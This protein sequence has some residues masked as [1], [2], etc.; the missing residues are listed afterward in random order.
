MD[1]AGP[2]PCSDAIGEPAETL[3]RHVRVFRPAAD[4]RDCH[5]DFDDADRRRLHSRAAD[6]AISANRAAGNSGAN[7]LHRGGR[8]HDRAIGRGADRAADERGRQ[9]E[10]HVLD[11]RE[12][13][14]HSIDR[15]FRR[16]DRP[17]HRSGPDPAARGAS[18]IAIAGRREQLRR[19]GQEIDNGAADAGFAL[20][21]QRNLRQHFSRELRLHQSVRSTH[22]TAGNWKR[23][24]FR[25]RPIRDALVGEAGS[26]R[27][28]WHHGSGHHHGGAE[29][30]QCESCG[31][32]R[33]RTDS[34]RTEIYL[35]RARA[36]SIANAGGIRRDRRS[37]ES[38]RFV[39]SGERHRADR[40]RRANLQLKRQAERTDLRPFSLCI[41][42]REPT[43]SK[44][45]NQCAS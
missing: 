34:E 20:F 3:I 37:C 5:R 13:R 10:L 27:E 2:V 45:R 9:H 24:D 32:G 1:A 29:A 26:T 4:R 17:E 14:R 22:A 8:A 31:P 7:A 38:G 41:S 18:A 19:D 30:E 40:S 23:P 44:P 43:P 39:C 25:R 16:R 6:R 35:H 11:Q 42:C 12:Q 28:A 21:A 33:R 15:Q 36:G